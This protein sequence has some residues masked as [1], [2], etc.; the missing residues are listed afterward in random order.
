LGRRYLAEQFR[1]WFGSVRNSSL[2]EALPQISLDYPSIAAFSNE[3]LKIKLH[4]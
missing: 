1:D 4:R 3:Q 2:P